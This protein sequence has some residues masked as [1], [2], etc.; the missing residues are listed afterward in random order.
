ME[1]GKL[2]AIHG[3]INWNTM[4]LAENATLLLK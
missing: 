4:L 2:N 3:R 1:S